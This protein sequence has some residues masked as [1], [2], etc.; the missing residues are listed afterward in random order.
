[1]RL[2]SLHIKG[3]KSFANDTTIHFN[4]DVIGVVGPN[5]SG[6][7]NVV[8]AI[9]WVLGEQKSKDL[10]LEQ[11]ADV[12]F[13]GTKKRKEASSATVELT[14]INDKGI[15]P[16]EYNQVCIS[17]I[18]YRSGESEY[19]LNNVV[20][21][22]KDIKSLLVDTGIGSNSYAIIALGMVDDIL[23]DKDDSRRRMFE[24]AAGIS[25]FKT[26]KKETIQKLKLANDDLNRVEDLLF[27]IEVNMK[28]LEKQAKKTKKYFELK[29]EY[30]TVAINSAVRS[31]QELKASYK[32]LNE[33]IKAK[34]DQY[35]QLQADI[36]VLEADIQKERKNILDKEIALSAKQKELG[37]IIANIRSAESDKSLTEQSRNFKNQNI[38][39]TEKL[40]Q[41]LE[42]QKIQLTKDI[43]S[44]E[45]RVLDEKEYTDELH[46][47]L[48]TA[49]KELEDIR[50]HYASLKKEE[51]SRLQQITSLQNSIFEIEK[52]IAVKSNQIDG[53]EKDNYN[54]QQ[55]LSNFDNENIAIKKLFE[56]KTL[57]KNKAEEHLQ[58]LKDKENNQK[59]TIRQLELNRD[60][61][62]A[63]LSQTNR[64]LDAKQN[65]YD[66]LQSMIQSYEGFP[67]SIKY[68]S[69][70][71]RKDVPIL[72]DLL[73]VEEQYKPVIEG[74]L[75]PYLNYFVVD[76][77]KSASQAIQILGGAQKGKANFFLI[78]QL[79]D[80]QN[81]NEINADLLPAIQ[82]VKTDEK[83]VPLLNYI[84]KNTY[85]YKGGIDQINDLQLPKEVVLLSS[86]GSFHKTA[87][88]LSGG[89]VGLFEGK[90]I[91]RKKNLEKLEKQLSE[92]Q[93]KKLATQQSFDKLRSEI[94]VLKN[95][96]MRKTIDEANSLFAR[97]NQELVKIS[98]EIENIT[99]VKNQTIE[100]IEGNQKTKE[101]YLKQKTQFT[102]SL[103]TYVVSL[104]ELIK[105]K[106]NTGKSLD[107]LSETLSKASEKYNSIN[108]EYIKQQNLLNSVSKDLEYKQIRLKE[109]SQRQTLEKNKLEREKEEYFEA[110]EKLVIL[111]KQLVALYKEKSGFQGELSTTE[112][113]Y[114]Q[115]RV[116]ITDKEEKAKVL[117]RQS[118]QLQITINQQKDKYN[119]VKYEISAVGDR[120]NI[121]FGVPVNDIINLTPDETIPREE[122]F[123]KAT[124][125]KIRIQNYGEINPLALEAY[126]EIKVRY[127][128]I[129]QQKQDILEA[130]ESLKQT[131]KEIETTAVSQFMNAFEQIRTN[132]ISVFRHLFTEDDTC[133]LI[134]LDESDPLESPIDIIAKPRGKKPKS[135]SQLS[136]GEKTLTATAL[137]FA[138]Y[139]LK[140]APFCIFDEV[141]APLD[142]ANIQKFNN[143]IKN[144]SANSQFII[145]THNKA[146]M[147]AVDVLYGV[148]MQESGVSSVTPVDFRALKDDGRFDGLG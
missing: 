36:S 16:T 20:C 42:V 12:I 86:N 98:V 10:R 76:N 80:V 43:Q 64:S 73:D 118:N 41:D 134:L 123:D 62:Q 108:I 63:Q 143:I 38:K 40:L 130:Q 19:R 112:K 14:F 90:K 31:I 99:K 136:G 15:L 44:L 146:T 92:L 126:E 46:A 145:V 133:D 26:R 78:D 100:K 139:L 49:Q 5:G 114:H 25:K 121:E 109:I 71:W 97:T 21:R 1:M 47:N 144:F 70:N 59:E 75:E 24:Q 107:S 17:R 102:E 22:L 79:P 140:P 125:L 28:N 34:Q 51:D 13:N 117:T 122:E 27:E 39:N 111:D 81:N 18:L 48:A 89:A 141:D 69:Q 106:E 120:L 57:E 2:Q 87:T 56:S 54:L 104:D 83:Y 8:D 66:L 61:I 85:I 137:L 129:I 9:R 94:G 35:N 74:Y 115:A 142:D 65:E 3:F 7:S 131:I 88:T 77:L 37:H 91:G 101:E 72:S 96:D 82:T 103:A 128:L 60:E 135:L 138:L 30:K 29:D 95:N 84:L 4:E 58:N 33:E 45:E 116:I 53:I 52:N 110:A 11:M 55:N 6:K 124:S 148:Y 147:T 93:A 113:A 105:P 132:F 127:D 50:S 68:L 119:E 23:E 32:N 67:E